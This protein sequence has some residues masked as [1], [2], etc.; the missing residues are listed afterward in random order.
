MSAWQDISTAPKDGTRILVY[1][2]QGPGIG[3]MVVHHIDMAH[4][5]AEFETGWDLK[6]DVPTSRGA[7][8]D[9]SVAD[10]GAEEYAELHPTHWMPLPEPPQP[11]SP[12]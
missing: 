8:T 7:W 12:R 10:W 2:K 3:G 4:W 9:L 1:R 6:E 11:R 5:D